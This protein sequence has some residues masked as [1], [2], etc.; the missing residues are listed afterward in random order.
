[1]QPSK[2]P[3]QKERVLAFLQQRGARGATSIEIA[4]ATGSMRFGARIKELREQ[5]YQIESVREGSSEDGAE[6]WRYRYVPPVEFADA[7][8]ETESTAST[9]HYRSEAA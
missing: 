5:G 1:M 4:N 3:T 7:L 6:V 2:K 9:A 8:F